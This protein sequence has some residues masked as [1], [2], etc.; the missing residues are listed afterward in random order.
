METPAGS[1]NPS[2]TDMEVIR[3][4]RR[5]QNN[6]RSR[7]TDNRIKEGINRLQV[8]VPFAKPSDSRISKIRQ[9]I[10]YIKFLQTQLEE[11]CIKA[12]LP[13]EPLPP[14]LLQKEL[15]NRFVDPK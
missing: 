11:T 14:L 3:E 6:A 15:G 4:R 12:E 13:E 5:R 9:A 1:S 10:Q 8:A 2:A 7:R